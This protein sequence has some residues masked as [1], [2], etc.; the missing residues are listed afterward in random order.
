MTAR[1]RDI[2]DMAET[3]TTIRRR[4][5]PKRPDETAKEFL[6]RV[7]KGLAGFRLPEGRPH[8]KNITVV[9]RAGHG[10]TPT[11]PVTARSFRSLTPGPGRLRT[12]AAP[13][14]SCT[15]TP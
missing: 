11:R 9:S 1:F 10:W 5:T 7:N 14:L 3:A 15:R 12:R 2:P 13:H 6:G 8:C 4:R